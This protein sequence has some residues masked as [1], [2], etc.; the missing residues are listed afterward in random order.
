MEGMLTETKMSH[1]EWSGRGTKQG[2]HSSPLSVE[3][4]SYLYFLSILFSNVLC[5]LLLIQDIIY[6]LCGF[7]SLGWESRS[8]S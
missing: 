1:S 8:E 7:E 2:T 3:E 6:L 4:R 5:V